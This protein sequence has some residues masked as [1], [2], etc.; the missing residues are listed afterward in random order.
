MPSQKVY[1]LVTRQ[2]GKQKSI[3][4]SF[5]SCRVAK[6]LKFFVPKAVAEAVEDTFFFPERSQKEKTIVFSLKSCRGSIKCC[7]WLRKF[8]VRREID[9]FYAVA[10]V[11]VVIVY[12]ILRIMLVGTD[13]KSALSSWTRAKAKTLYIRTLPK[14]TKK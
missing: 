2:L 11:L 14:M 13:Y 8:R 12:G 10:S 1:F 4:F 6:K 5:P 9:G 7:F 3:L